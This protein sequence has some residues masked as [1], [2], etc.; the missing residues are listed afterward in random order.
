MKKS[1]LLLIVVL[2][3][4]C[5]GTAQYNPE[6]LGYNMYFVEINPATMPT[7]DF[8]VKK[9]TV[10]TFT[11][12]HDP[13]VTPPP[14]ITPYAPVRTI[15]RWI[16]NTQA[17]WSGSDTTT[18]VQSVSFTRGMYEVVV[19]AV[20]TLQYQSEYSEPLFMKVTAIIATIPFNL[21]VK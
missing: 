10:L 15:V 11:W 16:P 17:L 6:I 5:P 1:F 9:D 20:D 18:V 21:K 4:A 2:F 19:T 8:L 3:Y 12:E 14:Y 7:E 13:T